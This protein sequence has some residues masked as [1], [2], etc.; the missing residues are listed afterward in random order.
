MLKLR[1]TGASFIVNFEEPVLGVFDAF[2]ST[3]HVTVTSDISIVFFAC[4]RGR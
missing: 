1:M 4:N 3:S 2:S